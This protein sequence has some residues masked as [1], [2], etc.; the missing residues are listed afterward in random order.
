MLILVSIFK[1]CFFQFVPNYLS[2]LALFH[3]VLPP[4]LV[5][6]FVQFFPFFSFHFISF[7]S[8]RLVPFFRPVSLHSSR[9]SNFFLFVLFCPFLPCRLVRP[10][11]PFIPFRPF[12]PFRPVSSQFILF[13]PMIEKKYLV[14]VL[15]LVPA[16]RYRYR[17][18]T[19]TR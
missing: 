13:R 11:V 12:V 4:F 17:P 19:G 1:S 2:G 3:Q 6:F 18:S 14:P 9:L 7:F 15:D 10:V 5:P 8:S 16:S